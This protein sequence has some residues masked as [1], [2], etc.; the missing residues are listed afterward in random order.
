MDRFDLTYVGAMN[1]FAMVL[2]YRGRKP[3][4]TNLRRPVRLP[5]GSEQGPT[6]PRSAP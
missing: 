3:E 6:G 2:R 4:A 5:I 1:S